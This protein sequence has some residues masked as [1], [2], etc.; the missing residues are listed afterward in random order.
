[1]FVA[2]Y[3]DLGVISILGHMSV[4]RV[5]AEVVGEDECTVSKIG[6]TVSEYYALYLKSLHSAEQPMHYTVLSKSRR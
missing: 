1:M 3:K 6:C 4:R 5:Q 2:G